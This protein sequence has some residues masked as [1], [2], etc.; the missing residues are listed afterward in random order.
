MRNLLQVD[1]SH[2]SR[3]SMGDSW[4]RK[5]NTPLL[6]LHLLR[7][8][9]ERST[10]GTMTF[11]F[12]VLPPFPLPPSPFPPVG[13][14]AKRREQPLGAGFLHHVFPT[15]SQPCSQPGVI[16]DPSDDESDQSGGNDG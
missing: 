9:V 7:L 13:V 16:T 2:G 3:Y 12:L 5:R 11:S 4:T 15:Q 8:R 6:L 14:C 10:H 1:A